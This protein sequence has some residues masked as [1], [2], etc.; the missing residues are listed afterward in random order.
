MK[1][2]I[3]FVL[4]LLLFQAVVFAAVFE[5]MDPQGVSF[6]AGPTDPVEGLSI[7]WVE[8][9]LYPKNVEKGRE[10][11][12]E[13]KLTSRV[14]KVAA[15]FDFDNSGAKAELFSDNGMTWNRVYKIP[16]AAIGGVH[17]AKIIIEG[18]DGKSLTRTLNFA[19]VENGEKAAKM[20]AYPVSVL[21]P[22]QVVENGETIRQLLPG[23]TVTALYKEPFYRVKLSDGREGWIEAS[24]VKD[25]AEELYLMGYKSYKARDYKNAEVCYFQA[26]SLDANH[27]RAR[28]WLAKTYIKQGKW[29][30][31]AAQL[32]EAIKID[33]NM[34]VARVKLG[35]IYKNTGKGEEAALEW[36]KVLVLDPENRDASAL[37]GLKKGEIAIA[38]K[39][40]EAT[41]V[42]AQDFSKNF[43][44]D[45][46]SIVQAAQTSKGTSISSAVKSVLALT[47]S[48]GTKIYEDGWK[49]Q[50]AGKEFIVS[51]ACRQERNGRIEAENFDWKIDPDSRRVV[52]SND[53][54]RLLM[55]RW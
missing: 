7:A 25:P 24:K 5:D 4:F 47:R 26:I 15:E 31:A 17:I 38:A 37:L 8:T 3:L 40:P 13:V 55:N 18:R 52:A 19:V 43:V 16:S 27:L 20:L 48:L 6:K 10:V 42:K 30:K 45:A 54:S 21:S 9:A 11:F 35:E 22:A 12:I 32:K 34:L 2:T 23:V 41:D 36:S 28:Y 39:L 44:K 49:V 53:N 33:P 1:K 29:D 46:V 50:S 14:G 51:Y